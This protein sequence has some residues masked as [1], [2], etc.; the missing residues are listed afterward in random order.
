MRHDEGYT[1]KTL[2][3]LRI[4]VLQCPYCK[5]LHETAVLT[6]GQHQTSCQMQLSLSQ[7]LPQ[8]LTLP[9]A[10]I[11]PSSYLLVWGFKPRANLLLQSIKQWSD[12]RGPSVLSEYLLYHS[13]NKLS[14][15]IGS[16]PV[17]PSTWQEIKGGV[18][19]QLTCSL[20]Y[21]HFIFYS[22]SPWWKHFPMLLSRSVFIHKQE[23]RGINT[24]Y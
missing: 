19:F 16:S 9:Q 11:L 4:P 18:F 2:P 15:G 21:T 1:W 17:S 12:V 5:M 8:F 6:T 24:L 20:S 3:R 23:G 13:L 14:R 10:Q 7:I 22:I